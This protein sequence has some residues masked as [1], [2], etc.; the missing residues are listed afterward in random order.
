MCGIKKIIQTKKGSLVRDAKVQRRG[1]NFDHIRF[2]TDVVF[3]VA[4]KL[5]LPLDEAFERM[6]QYDGLISLSRSYRHRRVVGAKD[7]A[8]GISSGIIRA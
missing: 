7:A 1:L 3:E 8:R 6:K 5:E 4:K 2:N